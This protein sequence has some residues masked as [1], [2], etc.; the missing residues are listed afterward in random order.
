MPKNKLLAQRDVE[1]IVR[2]Q[3]YLADMRTM[4]KG[5]CYRKHY[6]YMG[7]SETELA[8]ILAASATQGGE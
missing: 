8:A 4:N 1:E 2:F 5:D 7:L 3:A 6:L